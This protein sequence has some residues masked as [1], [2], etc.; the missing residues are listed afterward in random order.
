V[1]FV[2]EI[3]VAPKQIPCASWRIAAQN[4]ALAVAN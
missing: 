2:K 3:A 1:R 4:A